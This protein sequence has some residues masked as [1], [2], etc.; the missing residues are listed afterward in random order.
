MNF[1]IKQNSTLPLLKYPLDYE[2]MENYGINNEMF[3]NIAVTFSMIN[4]HNGVYEIANVSAGYGFDEHSGEFVL[5]YR[6]KLS[7]TKNSGLYTGEFKLDF[8]EEKD[9]GKVTIPTDDTI[10]IK[11][12]DSITKTSVF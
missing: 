1:F 2:L 5:T 10:L 7:D 8:L 6:F 4:L 3:D 9:C 12:G 11:I